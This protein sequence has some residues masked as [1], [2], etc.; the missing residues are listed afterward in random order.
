[1]MIE[2]KDVL[3][4]GLA[5]IV[6]IVLIFGGVKYK[7]SLYEQG[8]QD[9]AAYVINEVL[10]FATNC[11]QMPITQGNVT[12]NLLPIECINQNCIKPE[13]LG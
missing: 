3:M 9:G 11:Q 7:N 10:K 2:L 8:T 4:W 1:M 5:I 6:V 13:C 12:I